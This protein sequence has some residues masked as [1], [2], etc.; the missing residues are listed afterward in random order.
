VTLVSEI[1]D[2]ADHVEVDVSLFQDCN[3]WTW[4]KYRIEKHETWV[5][6]ATLDQQTQTW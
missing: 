4:A 2:K 1:A 3:H 6:R 5:V